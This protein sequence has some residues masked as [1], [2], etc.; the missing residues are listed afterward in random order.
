LA[1]ILLTI[2]SE[3]IKK[4]KTNFD[5]SAII[6]NNQ[7]IVNAE[8]DSFDNFVLEIKEKSKNFDYHFS[9]LDVE[10]LY[11][12]LCFL[13][14]KK[15]GDEEAK[16]N[17]SRSW[18]QLKSAIN[19]WFNT[20]FNLDRS[21]YYPIV[22]N[23]L[24]KESSDLK[25]AISKALK[26]FRKKYEIEIREKEERDVYNLE[27]PDLET[28]FTE[29]FEEVDTIYKNAYEKFFI[30][31]KYLGKDNEWNFIKFLESQE[32][33]IWWHKQNDSGR[34]VFAIEY[35]DSI[36]DKN[37]LFYPDFIIKTKTGIYLLD[38]KNNITAKSRETVDKSQ[39]LQAWIRENQ[40]KYH[41]KIH[42]GI[43]IEEYPSWKINTKERY[44]Y[45]NSTDWDKL[46]F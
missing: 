32:N 9:Q 31:K 24:I 27:L 42:G 7:I 18:G 34:G 11:N 10:R 16:Y 40:S 19:V 5:F 29:D 39:A 4:T 25:T 43:V 35:L 36:E 8:I 46:S 23:E 22:V 44:V 21:D 2:F 41:F 45:E 14:L 20:R 26:D 3:N 30:R 17:P 1:K 38:P 12:L 6:V 28:S 15:Q 13:E 33:V 37:R